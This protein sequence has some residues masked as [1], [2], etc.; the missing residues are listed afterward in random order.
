MNPKSASPGGSSVKSRAPT[1]RPSA[2]WSAASSQTIRGVTS[3]S[4]AYA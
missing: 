3:A 1:S 4:E 2:I